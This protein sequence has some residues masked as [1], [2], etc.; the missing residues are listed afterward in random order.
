MIQTWEIFWRGR[1]DSLVLV[2]MALSRLVV[3]PHS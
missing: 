1:E 3:S 2:A